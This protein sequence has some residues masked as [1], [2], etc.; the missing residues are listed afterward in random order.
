MSDLRKPNIQGN[1]HEKIEAISRYLYQLVDQLQFEFEQRGT[2]EGGNTVTVVKNQG[3]G[4]ANTSQPQSSKE[5]FESIKNYIIASGEIFN[6]YHKKIEGKLI[7]DKAF[8]AQY[9]FGTYQ[10]SITQ[11]FSAVDGA[12]RLETS[13]RE[14]IEGVYGQEEKYA[15]ILKEQGYLKAGLLGDGTYGVEIGYVDNVGE[16]SV[17]QFTTKRLVLFRPGGGEGAWIDNTLMHADVFE[18]KS[19]FL[20]GGFEEKVDD[21]SG[22]IT[23][24]WVGKA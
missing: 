6:A 12:I 20:L 7:E 24:R 10:K 4:V 17:G 19:K 16:K 11:E 9:E 3:G 8:V 14:A 2:S 5:V 13:K 1:D 23:T 21:E 22:N 18:A 15:K